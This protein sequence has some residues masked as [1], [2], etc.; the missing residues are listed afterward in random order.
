MVVKFDLAEKPAV[1]VTWVQVAPSEEDHTSFALVVEVR[2]AKAH[3]FAP[4][5]LSKV[6]N[7]KPILDP[8]AVEVAASFQLMPS[9]EFQISD[10]PSPP[11]VHIFP[12]N[13]VAPKFTRVWPRPVVV[14]IV[15]VAPEEQQLAGVSVDTGVFVD[16]AVAVGDAL[17]EGEFV[18]L[19]VDVGEKI[20]QTAWFTFALTP[21]GLLPPIP[22]T[23]LLKITLHACAPK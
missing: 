8:I 19:A 15:H 23:V 12:P 4:L 1:G 20:S 2:P 18:G 5:P 9:T 16:E 13:T 22:Q 11:V 7:P 3:I 6:K 21:D 10:E 17:G 14:S